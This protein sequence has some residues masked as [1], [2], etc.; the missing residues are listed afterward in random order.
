M[1][2]FEVSETAIFNSLKRGYKKYKELKAND[3]KCEAGKIKGWCLAL[4]EIIIKF[5]PELQ[6]ELDV[7]KK[8]TLRRVLCRFC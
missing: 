6:A 8:I 7:L 3:K 2:I 1:R 4:E 5:A